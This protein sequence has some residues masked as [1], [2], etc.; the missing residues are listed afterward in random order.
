MNMNKS[1]RTADVKLAT[2]AAKARVSTATV[3]RVLNNKGTV[4]PDTRERV[5]SVLR[6]HHL[7]PAGKLVGLLVPDSSNPFFAQ[8]A[9]AFEREFELADVLVVVSSSEGKVERE[10]EKLNRLKSINVDGLIFVSA[11]YSADTLPAL[12]ADR[13]TPVLVFDRYLPVGNLDSVTVDSIEGTQLAVDYLVAYGHSKIGYLK[14]L[15]GTQTAEE[16]EASYRAAM[17]KGSM[18]VNE[19][20]V[21]PGDY[22][23]AAGR[24]CAERLLSVDRQARPTAV[25]TANDVMAIGLLQRLQEERL[26]VPAELSVVG[27]DN[28]LWGEWTTP[29]LTTIAQPIHEM[30]HEAARL[31]LHRMASKAAVPEPKHLRI[32]PTLIPRRSVG[33]PH[34][35]RA[36]LSVL[37]RQGDW[38]VDRQ[39]EEP[40]HA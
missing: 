37:H 38:F 1:I 23:L 31:L 12:V 3:S 29:A 11:G 24:V 20:W 2:V 32:R 16:R 9:F 28:I 17:K 21:Y 19:D 8:L 35:V 15:P 34:D 39:A 33:R 27:F 7:S 30:V 36:N 14:G 6:E 40:T 26:Q 10:L 5:I 22:T 18:E 4:A 13:A 25:L